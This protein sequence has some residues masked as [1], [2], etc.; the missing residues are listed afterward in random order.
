[1]NIDYIREFQVLAKELNFS[2][3]AQELF[4][5]QPVLSRHIAS[6]EEEIGLP[7][8]KRSTHQVKLT[9]FGKEALETFEDIMQ[10][11]DTLLE[12][13]YNKNKNINSSGKLIVGIL[14]YSL[15]YRFGEFIPMFRKKYPNINLELRTY[16]P[17]ELYQDIIK[18]N[19]DIGALQVGKFPEIDQLYIH[20]FQEFSMIAGMSNKHLLAKKTK[21]SLKDLQ[22]E[23]IIELKEDFC[24]RITTREMLEKVGI[25]F[26][27]TIVS[28]NVETISLTIQE[29]NGVCLMGEDCKW[30]KK[31]QLAYIPIADKAFVEKIAFHYHKRN[32][33]PLIPT[34]L[35]EI[36][37]FFA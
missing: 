24:S 4:M 29:S 23:T 12:I 37:S 13:A 8:L 3:A 10:K 30:Q 36:D 32:E 19:I 6:L 14:Y 7:L 26:N 9:E 21:I 16:Q 11:Y 25:V 27:R 35:E 28:E 18:G 2:L 34:W 5:S 17:H 22:N 33:N 15:D 31:T 1:M 20:E